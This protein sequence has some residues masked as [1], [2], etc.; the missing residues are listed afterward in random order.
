MNTSLIPT[1][2]SLSVVFSL[3]F[4]I[5]F[6]IWL[7]IC[8]RRIVDGTLAGLFWFAGAALVL[9]VMVYTMRLEFFDHEI[10]SE[11]L[12]LSYLPIGIASGFFQFMFALAIDNM[13]SFFSRYKKLVISMAAG[14][15][16][17]LIFIYTNRLHGLLI[18]PD[19]SPD[20]FSF[21]PGYVGLVIANA[22][23]IAV[24]FVVMF[25]KASPG[26]KLT[27]SF[28]S[29]LLLDGG[30]VFAL[31]YVFEVLPDMPSDI[32]LVLGAT[33]LVY[34]EC[35]M[36]AGIIPRSRK[37]QKLFT[38]SPLKLQIVD[39]DGRV[40]MMSQQAI[41]VP[42][43]VYTYLSQGDG[44]FF[45]K[46]TN[47]MYYMSKIS[48]GSVIWQEDVNSQVLTNKK[49]D[50]NIRLLES[51]NKILSMQR[52]LLTKHAGTRAKNLLLERL[53]M[54]LKTKYELLID[55]INELQLKTDKKLEVARITLLL[56]YIKRR[57]NLFFR[58]IET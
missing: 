6:I 18:V 17:V 14:Y 26:A 42:K 23:L 54:D 36:R 2:N 15:A 53:D 16:L 51:S 47:T 55:M 57:C 3:A 4:V 34:F 27:W 58:E 25:R 29:F 41:P 8:V 56:V 10:L 35:C 33:F 1:I 7:G 22:V 30:I 9:W 40:V 32:T 28:T 31:L 50:M 52:D 49:I 48:G 24:S 12:K 46:R 37:Y 5:I 13:E 21:G 19:G 39:T 38:F 44:E 11:Y 20:G 45:D 43:R